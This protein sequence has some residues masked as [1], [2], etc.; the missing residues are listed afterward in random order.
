MAQATRGVEAHVNPNVS[1]MASRLRDFV[2]MNPPA[3][4]GSKVGEDHQEFLDEVYKIVNAMGVTSREKAK[5]ASYQL[6]DVAQIWFTQ[7]KANRP[8]EAG[9]IEWEE[10]KGSIPW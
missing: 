6:K 2:R 3:F 5:L 4:I 10:F 9:P 8:L 1:T 7:W